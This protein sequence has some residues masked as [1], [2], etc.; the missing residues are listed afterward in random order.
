MTATEVKDLINSLWTRVGSNRVGDEDLRTVANA[1]V[2]LVAATEIDLFPDWAVGLTFQTDGSDDGKYCKHPDTN[3]KKRIFETKVDDNIGNEPPTD[4]LITSDANWQ[5]ISQSAKSG[6]V[7]WSAGVYGEG[8]IVVAWNHSTEGYNHYVLTDPARPFTSVDIEAEITAGKWV[9][10][11]KQARDQAI[12][13]AVIGLWDDRGN[14]DASVNTFPA[15]GGSGTAG[16]ILKGDIWTASVAGTLGGEAVAIG[17]TIRAIADTPGQTAS[18]WALGE[19]NI[20]Y[21]PE[22]QANKAPDF[23]TV[24]NTLYPTVQAVVNYAM[25]QVMTSVGDLV[26]GGT[27]GAPT[28]IAAGTDG[29]VLTMVSGV[30]AWA[31]ASGGGSS[32]FSDFTAAT[33]GNTINHANYTQEWQWNTLAGASGLKL[34]TSSTAAA[35]D[36]QTLL[37]L[38]MSGANGTS[39]QT[40]YAARFINTHTGTASTN[41]AGYFEANGG[42]TNWA[43]KTLGGLDVVAN[44]S[45]TIYAQFSKSGDATIPFQFK[46]VSGVNVMFQLR[47]SN[48]SSGMDF[49]TN[50]GTFIMANMGTTFQWRIASSTNI[51]IG[52][53]SGSDR[54]YI[55]PLNTLSMPA[56]SFL[57]WRSANA[58]SAANQNGGGGFGWIGSYWNGS[59]AV[60]R[61]FYARAVPSTTTNLMASWVLSSNIATGSFVDILEV[62][63]DGVLKLK[64]IQVLKPLSGGRPGSTSVGDGNVTVEEVISAFSGTITSSGVS[65]QQIY[66]PTLLSNNSSIEVE[67]TIVGIKTDGTSSFSVTRKA[68]FR[69][70]NSGTVTMDVQGTTDLKELTAS[71]V[72]SLALLVNSGSPSATLT[73]GGSSGTYNIK[74]ISKVIIS[75]I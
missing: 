27:A 15:S 46:L 16:A 52:T 19:G 34:T 68:L 2:D 7:E 13:A 56:H 41:V 30:P 21:V 48:N 14:Y 49:Q 67:F 51:N 63:Q 5:E 45:D 58:S 8:L 35:S 11:G 18:N 42:T 62:D 25:Q 61:G 22:D 33:A 70:D 31:A 57:T 26:R 38:N 66:D 32:V 36:L 60:N 4:P 17:D 1:I 44:S 39:T 73:M 75:K 3:G 10:F 54:L 37:E 65:T 12:A 50:G 23:S 69:K 9:E 24:N 47:N 71:T 20:D 55:D 64:G 40:T 28:R 53:S 74:G 59:A 29:Y 6:I 43:L 72:S